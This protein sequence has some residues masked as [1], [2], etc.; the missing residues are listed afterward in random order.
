MEYE[1]ISRPSYSLVDVALAAG[2]KIVTDSGAMAWMDPN[3]KAKTQARGGILSGIKRK[4]L[5]GESFFQN[6]YTAEGSPG[7]ISLAPGPAGDIVAHQLSGEL[8]LEKGAYLGSETGVEVDAKFGGL[9]GFFNEGFFV[10]RC[11]GEGMLFFNAYGEIQEIDLDGTYTVDN[12]YA[13]AWEPTLEYRLTR[14]RRIRS[15]LFSDQILLR[16]SGRGKLWIQSRSPNA[17][18]NWVHPYRPIK[19]K[20]ND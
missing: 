14:A 19:R 10:L 5:S 3:I 12:G 11:T 6:T 2:E 9:R 13:V 17:I 18:A 4:L 7:H 16:F 8:F 15:F 1:I 20:R